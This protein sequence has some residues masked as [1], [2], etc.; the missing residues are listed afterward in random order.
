MNIQRRNFS[1]FWGRSQWL[2][3]ILAGTQAGAAWAYETPAETPGS[4]ATS[5]D[6]A[7]SPVTESTLSVPPSKLEG[8]TIQP[9]DEP[10]KTFQPLKPISESAK[11]RNAAVTHYMT[12][13]IH[14]ENGKLAEALESYL[15][16]IEQDQTAIVPY[17]S[18]IPLL[19]QKR[20]F[21]RSQELSLQAAEKSD[22]GYT[23]LLAVASI[24]ARQDQLSESI[25]LLSSALELPKYK[26]NTFQALAI[27]RDLGLF[28]R[29]QGNFKLAAEQY[30]A[31]F[32]ACVS[33]KLSADEQEKLMV[34][35][36]KM[37]DEF[38]DTFLKVENP[39][40]A[41]KAF[42]EAS[43]YREARPGQNSYNLATVFR[44]TGQPE[45]ALEELQD[46]FN[47]QLQSRGRAAYQLLK[48]LLA[49]L[50]REQEL[51]PKLE[52]LLSKDEHNDS[53]R[54]FLADEVLKSGDLAKAEQ[55]FTKGQPE[56]GDP[57]AIVGM[58]PIYRQQKNYEKLLPLLTKAFTSIPRADDDAATAQMAPDV[59]ELAEQFEQQIK[60][61]E[62]DEA[63]FSGLTAYAR[64][65]EATSEEE[66]E[67][68]LDFVSAYILG[69]LS[70]EADR[71]EDATH[72]YKLA[73]SMRN[74]PPAT[75]YREFAIYLI[76]SQQFDEALAV[77]DE[78]M[79]HRSVQ[80][81]REKP[82]F[83][84]LASYGYAMKGDTDKALEAIRQAIAQQPTQ[85][86]FNYQEGWVL[87]H[88]KR[89]DEAIAHFER[90][91]KT[92]AQ[93]KEYVLKCRF[94]ISN[95]YVEKGEMERGEKI[96]EEVLVT[97]PD[98]A[99][100][101]NDLG[102]LYADQGKNLERAEKMI[103]KALDHEPDNRA[104]QD[105]LGWVLFKLGRYE[106]AVLE[107]EKATSDKGTKD[108]T[109]MEHL[110]DC[111]EKVNRHEEAVA[112]WKKGL[113]T[114]ESKAKPS[115][116]LLKSLRERLGV[117]PAD[118]AEETLETKAPT[119]AE[120]SPSP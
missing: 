64:T 95:I 4:S 77:I 39:E 108:S 119:P 104:Y 48:E 62:E 18:A 30:E 86:M 105:S 24:L 73:I 71:K 82:T 53:L 40:L 27:R 85:S 22:E 54:F 21:Q 19:L 68:K 81:Q 69:K 91:M 49:Q 41:L 94:Q 113:E 116:K 88:G 87:F 1:G 114:E 12:G 93:D 50:N 112:A 57:R 11:S 26:E 15:K 55:L 79:Q 103:R 61:L 101:N 58:L 14:Q 66:G 109:L 16:S 117:Q 5:P 106:E 2:A 42:E 70:S 35:Q 37:F 3:L 110:G 13:R 6:S 92:F 89:Y 76:D 38:G 45:K 59:K 72:F 52:E 60:E 102:Y 99:Q 118:K 9:G 17:Q 67:E 10:L 23:L 43:K 75:L 107:M 31:V 56:V 34:N 25:R 98:N 90:S 32:Q 36:G 47:A 51:L 115:E 100:A 80:L 111:L 74:D 96:L 120:E 28:Y 65:L 78:A 46:Y 44:Q 20:E 97:N 8:L 29:I 7:E 83:H 63:A 84:Y 33:G